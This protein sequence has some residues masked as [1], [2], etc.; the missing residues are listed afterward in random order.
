MSKDLLPADHLV[1]V[2][3]PCK[4]LQRW[5]NNATTQPQH[6][7][8]GRLCKQASQSYSVAAKLTDSKPE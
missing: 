8:Q 6:K 7:V 5:L 4:D 3:L 2:V 1:L